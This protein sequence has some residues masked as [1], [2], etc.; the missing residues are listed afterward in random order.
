M[1][2]VV[3]A[4]LIADAHV[5]EHRIAADE[6]VARRCVVAP[7]S[8]TKGSMTVSVADGD[9]GIDEHGLGLEDGD[10]VV[11]QFAGF[12]LAQDGIELRQFAAGIDAEHLAGVAA[13][14]ARTGG[15]RAAELPAIW[16][17]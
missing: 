14:R 5:G 2:A 13:R 3:D 15:R 17:R 7:S 8:C 12:A 10:A 11:H 16:V 9:V 6:A 1:R 4:D